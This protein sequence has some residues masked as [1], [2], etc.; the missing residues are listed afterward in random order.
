MDSIKVRQN[1]LS[2]ELALAKELRFH[3][4]DNGG[5]Q[6]ALSSILAFCGCIPKA[7]DASKNLVTCRPGAL[8]G[9]F[10]L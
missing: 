5:T 9:S 2:D 8:W 10:F 1:D 7:G 6:A 4:P 3:I